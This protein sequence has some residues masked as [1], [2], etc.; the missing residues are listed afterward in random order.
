M[1]GLDRMARENRI[2]PETTPPWSWLLPVAAAAILMVLIVINGFPLIYDDTTAYMRRAAGALVVLLGPEFGSEWLDPGRLQSLQTSIVSDPG[3]LPE[4]TGE[5]ERPWTSGRSVYYGFTIYLLSKLGGLWAAAAFQALVAGALL[6]L[7]WF[8]LFELRSVP[9]FLL[10]CVLLTFLTSL[11]YFVGLIMP[12]IFAA[13]TILSVA[14]LATGWDKLSWRERG[15][16]IAIAGFSVM[17]HDSHLLLAGGLVILFLGWA[18]VGR[19]TGRTS[20]PSRAQVGALA[21]CL[22]AGVLGALVFNQAAIMATGQAPMRLPH[23]TAHIAGTEDGALFLQQQCQHEDWAVCEHA[24]EL[25]MSWLEFM[26]VREGIYRE[27]SLEKRR[28]LSEEQ[29]EI[30]AALLAEDAFSV[31]G[32]MVTE[33]LHQLVAIS[34][35][36]VNQKH[37]LERTFPESTLTEVEGTIL[38]RNEGLFQF[39]STVQEVVA[40][41]CAPLLIGA[42]IMTRKRLGRWAEYRQFTG[43]LLAGVLLNAAVCGVIAQVYDRFQV[44]VVW[45]LPFA[46]LIFLALH[47]ERRRSARAPHNPVALA[48]KRVG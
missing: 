44:R 38:A 18:I 45:L 11:A 26:F 4:V 37:M 43:L 30:A 5:A 34:Y 29:L 22:V 10:A 36:D 3:Q 41:L 14:L 23:I 8:R 16:T 17:A 40:F 46:L 6:Y 12:D 32:L 28:Q 42:V 27:A 19:A 15:L 2:R 24:D 25:P 35:V 20:A 33:T 9:L 31:I 47:I 48:S 21:S 1:S 13:F 39:L 7:T